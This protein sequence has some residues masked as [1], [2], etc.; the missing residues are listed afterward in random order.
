[1]STCSPSPSAAL[2]GNLRRFIW[3]RVFFNARFYYPVFTILFLDYGLT[4][5]QFAILNIVWAVTI[6]L[7]EVPSGAL[8]DILG[9][10]RLLVFAA[11]L[12]F[13][14]MALLAL[15]PIGPSRL[16]FIIF[17]L[18]RIFSGNPQPG[19]ILRLANFRGVPYR[20]FNG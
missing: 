15:V 6:V 17:L 7:A 4:L 9:R 19:K 13:F 2:E 11:V 1:M 10:K 14:E 3:F 8:A 18:N 16:L 12:M 20:P 5:E